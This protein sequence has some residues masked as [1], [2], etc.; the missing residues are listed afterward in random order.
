MFTELAVIAGCIG[1]LILYRLYRRLKSLQSDVDQLK[2]YVHDIQKYRKEEDENHLWYDTT[3]HTIAA[4]TGAGC[5]LS[6]PC[7]FVSF[8]TIPV[9]VCMYMV[10]NYYMSKRSDDPYNSEIDE[11]VR[12]HKVSRLVARDKIIDF[13]NRIYEMRCKLRD[14]FGNMCLFDK[15]GW[16]ER[17]HTVIPEYSSKEVADFI[18]K[19]YNE[20]DRQ[21]AYDPDPAAY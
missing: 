11:Y 18:T 16:I 12:Q 8:Y 6:I 14:A 17:I 4:V 13:R 7:L 19:V 5:F 20:V 2:D 21:P 9:T 1:A 10:H 3:G 15:V